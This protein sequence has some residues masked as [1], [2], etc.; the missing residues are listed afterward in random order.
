ML[1]C[2]TVRELSA[3]LPVCRFFRFSIYNSARFVYIS[4]TFSFTLFF[5]FL[6]DKIHALDILT[7]NL[8]H[9]WHLI[10]FKGIFLVMSL[11][12]NGKHDKKNGKPL[13]LKGFLFVKCV[14]SLSYSTLSL[15]IIT[16]YCLC[17]ACSCAAYLCAA[18]SCAACS[19]AAACALLLVAAC[20]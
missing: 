3:V 13:I 5:L 10:D 18:C 11:D 20:G 4:F 2:V 14:M 9:E 17:A 7:D 6:P 8:R 16:S 19:C 15:I 12:K 1:L